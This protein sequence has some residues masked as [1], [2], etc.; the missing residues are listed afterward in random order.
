MK[1]LSGN[2]TEYAA[3]GVMS[4]TSLDGLDLAAVRFRHT[5]H[6]WSFE[7]VA[8]ET[9]EYDAAWQQQLAAAP[10]LSGLELALLSNRFGQFT[11]A[12]VRNFL[13][14]SGFPAELV[15]SH[16][17]T[18]FHQPDKSLTLQIGNGAAIA[19]ETGL[20]VV[21]DFRMA[22]VALGGQ[23]APLVPAGDRLLFGHYRFCLNLGGFSNLSFE[24]NGQRRA[25]D[26]CPVN[27]VLN[28]LARQAGS[29]YDAGGNLGKSGQIH[30]KLLEEL[31]QLP[32]YRQP[33]PRSLGREW[34]EKNIMPLFLKYPDTTPNHLRTFYEHAARQMARFFPAGTEVLVTGGGAFNHFLLHRMQQLSGARMILP[35]EELISFKEALIFA[36]LGVLRLRNEINCLASVTGARRDSSGGAIFLP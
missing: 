10:Q 33:L 20:P 13:K 28:H 8:A 29:P 21:A 6:G 3:V 26:I 19:A 31:E 2:K 16:G 34:V 25:G 27:I 7:L 15:A 12:A 30:S 14:K 23:G 9:L 35:G 24:E 32:F 17:H 1:P 11:G 5:G 4:G 18:V 22:D 36:F